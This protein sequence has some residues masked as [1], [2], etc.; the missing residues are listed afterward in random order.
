MLKKCMLITLDFIFVILWDHILII[1]FMVDSVFYI[2][3]NEC[4]ICVHTNYIE[5]CLFLGC[6]MHLMQV[7]LLVHIETV[8]FTHV[9]MR[10]KFWTC[11]YLFCTSHLQSG[12]YLVIVFF[13]L[14][15]L[16]SVLPISSCLLASK[17]HLK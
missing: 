7:Q 1:S 13:V 5:V 15:T 2:S 17:S 10:C 4:C 16:S 6:E 14:Y 3:I 8:V 12:E 9:A 11:D